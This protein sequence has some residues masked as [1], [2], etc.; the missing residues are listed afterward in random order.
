MFI[1]HICSQQLSENIYDSRHDISKKDTIVLK[2]NLKKKGE[3]KEYWENNVCIVVSDKFQS[4]NYIE[5]VMVSYEPVKNYLLQEIK[6]K[7]CIP[8]NFFNVN[9]EESYIL[10]ENEYD[11]F[12]MQLKE[13][14]TYLTI[15]F[16]TENSTDLEK[17]NIY[18][19]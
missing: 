9:H 11:G 12:L 5:D 3:H 15:T 17:T 8:Y 4:F 14:T 19:I 7:P 1:I 10:Y 6:T 18:Y 2:Y 13:Y 16:Q